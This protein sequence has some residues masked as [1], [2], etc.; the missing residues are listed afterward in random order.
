M[1]SLPS[2]SI[3]LTPRCNQRCVYCYNPWRGTPD[4]PREE[5]DTAQVCALIDKVLAD[6]E[7]R[8]VTLSG[9][10][11]FL[12]DDILDI[13]DHVNARDLPASIISNGA[14]VTEPLARA[15]AQRRIH[16]VQVTL[17]GADAE[18][19]DAHC[20][21]GCFAATT[22]A[23]KRLADAGVPV[24]GSFLCTSQ[25]FDQ[26]GDT[27]ALMLRSG[28]RHHYA[29]N[30]INPSGHAAERVAD[31]MP[32]RSQVL[33]A[34][35]QADAFAA[36][37]DT[38]LHCTMPIPHCMVDEAEFAHISFGQCSAG[39]AAAE[40]AIDS[41]GNLKLCPLQQRVI[42]SL[43]ERSFA[44]LVADEAVACFRGAVP[45]FCRE[46]PHAD[47]CL[48]GCG[49]AAEWAFG[50]PSEA[51]PFLAQHIMLDFPLRAGIIKEKEDDRNEA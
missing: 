10:E 9:G 48:G 43:W 49:A 30:R 15:L 41:R 16:Y 7:L 47:A 14:L 23:A 1:L 25:S 32:T 12:R 28:I 34:L 21:D 17:A 5:M 18:T 13:I 27:L 35:E 26:A 20:G 4:P 51:D 50:T 24:G 38:T 8:G 46:C 11:P 33:V 22:R 31:L 29:F 6:A 36:A 39:S 37:H 2:I 40:Y 45:E 19:H 44:D 42:G 3:E